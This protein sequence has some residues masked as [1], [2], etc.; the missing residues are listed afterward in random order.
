MIVVYGPHCCFEKNKL[1][2]IIAPNFI[3]S[4][5][6]MPYKQ[7]AIIEILTFIEYFVYF[8]DIVDLG[9]EITMPLTK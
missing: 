8:N 1:K 9:I 5:L 2:E 3:L 7:T 4:S 6:F